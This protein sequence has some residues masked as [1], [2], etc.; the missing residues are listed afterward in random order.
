MAIFSLAIG[1]GCVYTDERRL[2]TYDLA[3]GLSSPRQTK[4]I[5]DELADWTTLPSFIPYAVIT[6]TYDANTS[7][8][9]IARRLWSNG[10]KE[11]ADLVLVLWP[12]SSPDGLIF[13]TGYLCRLAPCRLGF[14]T[15]EKGT[16]VQIEGPG[17]A[18]EAG[19]AEGD[20]PLMID[21]VRL[22]A[23]PE[24]QW[25]YPFY[26]KLAS[27]KPGDEY[28]LTWLRP[29]TSGTQQG[30]LRTI[31]NPPSHLQFP[32]SIPAPETVKYR[33]TP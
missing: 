11:K 14:I 15:D 16:V 13:T 22:E 25:T 1:A 4:L 5:Y 32:D 18:R 2:P 26:R 10:L 8:E 28:R 12:V 31:P 7:R 3:M 27:L 9:S 24:M 33:Y 29:G 19:L 6:H 30:V 17:G 21:D 23:S 20:T